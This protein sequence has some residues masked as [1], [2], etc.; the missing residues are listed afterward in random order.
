MKVNQLKAGA[1]LSYVSIFITILIALLYT[2]IMLRLLGQSE[3]GL[4]SLIGSLAGYL[5]IMDLGLGNA[6]VRYTARN[7][8]LGD[9]NTESRLNGMFLVLYSLIGLLTVII[10]VLLYSN[11]ESLFGNS[12]NY[13]ELEKAKL[14]VILLII[15]FALSFPLGIFGSIMQAYEKFIFV[16][17]VSIIRSLIIPLFTLPLLFFG[18][19]SVSMVVVSTVINISC[20]LINV[21]YCF[22]YLKIEFYFGKFN[23]K[24][25]KE[26]LG[27]SFFIFLNVIVDKLY[28]STDQVILGMV[29][30]TA[31]V[32]IYAVAMQFITLYMMFSTSVSGVF[33]PRITMMVA[34]KA[35]NEELTDY[36]I[37]I[38][39]I[40]YA[41]MALILSG[42]ILFGQ[43]FI[44]FWAGKNYSNAFYIV[45]L[46]M[47]PLTIPLIQNIGISILQAKDLHSFR[48]IVYIIIAILNILISIPLAKTYGVIGCAIAT[49]VTLI[50]GN[51]LIMNI[52][53]HRKIGL[54]IPLFWK[55]IAFMS[56]PIVL[57]LVFGYV[58]NYLIPQNGVIFLVSKIMLFSIIYLTLMLLIGFNRYEK[59]LFYSL[60]KQMIKKGNRTLVKL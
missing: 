34:N 42:F 41:I 15:N 18:Y 16:K 23:F 45:L 32:A 51:V 31:L 58:I 13:I 60:I 21:F 4:Y 26:V 40:Q 5:S 39:R 6:I 43:V 29:S 14:M 22:K 1:I 48:S 3:Y 38:G 46:V 33:L 25:V 56:I 49:G 9:K 8:A 11:I 24:M 47:I 35:N 27:Y 59:D 44:I 37:K 55:N 20:L 28:W 12:L 54:N 2:P 36:M 50:I 57:S 19:S 7:R 52:Y 17:L 30:G 10:G 53:Y